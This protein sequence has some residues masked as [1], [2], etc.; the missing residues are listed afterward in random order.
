MHTQIKRLALGG[1][2]AALVLVPWAG[3]ASGAPAPDP[4]DTWLERHAERPAALGKIADPAVVVGLGE[5]VHGAHEQ[6]TL[7]HNALR[8]LVTR[9]GFRSVAWEEDWTTGRAIDRYLASGHGRAGA[10]VR[11]MTG[12]WQSRE[13]VRTLRWLR[14]FN[15]D[16]PNDRVRFVGVEYYYTGRPAYDAVR[17]YVARVAPRLLPALRADFRVIYPSLA[18]AAAYAEEPRKA[19]YIRHAH[20]LA[21]LVARIDRPAADPVYAL[22]RRHTQQI[23]SFH[24]H[25]ALALEDQD[26]YRELHAAR[27][28]RWWQWHSDDRVVYWAAM[29]HTAAARH[30][31]IALPGAPDFSYRA[32]GSYLRDWYHRRY[33]SVTFT[34]DRGAVGLAPAEVTEQ[35][36]AEPGWFEASLAE[37]SRDRFLVDLRAHAPD[38]VQAWL[39]APITTRGM[40]WAP[41]STVTGGRAD[42]WFDVVVHVQRVTPQHAQASPRSSST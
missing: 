21:R 32:T 7:K 19:R 34:M 18:D 6:A 35:P 25:Y 10:L 38:P 2:A 3:P 17:R 1:L 39:A 24:E 8:R 4:V 12:Q 33:L 37:V 42:R 15:V 40:P 31:R 9:H 16:H 41:G 20:H 22:V 13:T 27:T 29:P 5:S 26:D 36:P 30:L 14:S 28:L 23:V 11:R